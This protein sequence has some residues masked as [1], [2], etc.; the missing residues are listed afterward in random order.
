MAYKA[1][2]LVVDDSP[3]YIRQITSML[4]DRYEIES[5]TSGEMALLAVETFNPDVI[6]LDYEMPEMDGKQ[7]LM[8]LK[9]NMFTAAIPVIFLT[10]VADKRY[11]KEV[12]ALRPSGYILKP[13]NKM[14]LLKRIAE[15]RG[16]L[17]DLE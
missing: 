8:K 16:E 4:K 13:V 6:L 12:L 9:Q 7:V 1:R 17:F 5:V 2:I 3:L 14:E 15:V 10:A 11:I